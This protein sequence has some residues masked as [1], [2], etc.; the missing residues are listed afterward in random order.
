MAEEDTVSFDPELLSELEE[1]AASRYT[2]DDADFIAHFNKG[3]AK[4]PILPAERFDRNR[5]RRGNF[6]HQDQRREGHYRDQRRDYHDRRQ[7]N[8][9]G[10]SRN[11]HD[12]RR[13]DRR[14]YRPERRSDEY[15]KRD[16]DSGKHY[17]GSSY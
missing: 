14:D 4:P 13:D 9:G 16:H 11:Y 8:F 5:Q 17:P 6:R 2:E 15:H 10:N 1:K 7:G 12:D 3:M